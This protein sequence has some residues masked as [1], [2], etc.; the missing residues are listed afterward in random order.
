MG[1]SR[2]SV[3]KLP[4]HLPTSTLKATESHLVVEGHKEQ[5]CDNGVVSVLK[6]KSNALEDERRDLLG[7]SPT[8]AADAD[9]G[10]A[11]REVRT[12]TTDS[13][14]GF[15]LHLQGP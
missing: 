12:T 6:F 7:E 3:T 2:S 9:A 4:P 5:E 10:T 8:S 1:H 11:Q 15:L 13:A 14:R